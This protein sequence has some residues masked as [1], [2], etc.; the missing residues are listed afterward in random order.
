MASIYFH[1]G[2]FRK[3][4]ELW[5][6]AVIAYPNYIATKY[7]LA[8]AWEKSGQTQKALVLIDEILSKRPDYMDPLILKGIILLKQGQFDEALSYFKKCS[9]RN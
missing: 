8:L 1:R 3:A 2:D 7:R 9:K 5:Q 6:A 4:A